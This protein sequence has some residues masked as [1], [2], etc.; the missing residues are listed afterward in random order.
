MGREE[1]LGA[2]EGEAGEVLV[3]NALGLKVVHGGEHSI[4]GFRGSEA[5]RLGI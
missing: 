5:A 2:E 3:E 1:E 4:G